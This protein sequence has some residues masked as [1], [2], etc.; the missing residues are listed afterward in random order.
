MAKVVAFLTIMLRYVSLGKVRLRLVG[1]RRFSVRVVLNRAPAI[2]VGLKRETSV[3]NFR[4]IATIRLS[5]GECFDIVR[6]KAT[7]NSRR[8]KRR[9]SETRPKNDNAEDRVTETIRL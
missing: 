6:K 1:V 9:F 2:V 5:R 8:F 7:N 3:G 4:L